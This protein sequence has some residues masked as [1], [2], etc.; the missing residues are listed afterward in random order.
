[1]PIAENRNGSRVPKKPEPSMISAVLISGG[2]TRHGMAVAGG[3]RAA[4]CT[5]FMEDFNAHR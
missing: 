4:A 3:G 2:A 5:E 1:M